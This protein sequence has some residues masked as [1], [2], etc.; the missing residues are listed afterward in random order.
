MTARAL[1]E[2]DYDAPIMD[3]NT[4]PLIDVML[5]LLIMFIVTIPLQTH[6]VKIDL[7]QGIIDRPPVEPVRNKIVIDEGGRVLWNGR[8]VE[9]AGLADALRR[10]QDVRPLPELH[11]KPVA[12]APYARVDEVLATAK[13]VGVANLGFVGNEQYRRF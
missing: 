1:D 8:V 7:P 4:T 3:M 9:L 2:R 10:S 5:V 6:A 11:I 12:E 13:R